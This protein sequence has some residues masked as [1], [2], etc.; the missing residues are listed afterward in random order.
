[1]P[2]TLLRRR[3]SRY[4]V[5]QTETGQ[6]MLVKMPTVMNDSMAISQ[7]QMVQSFIPKLR[8]LS[9]AFKADLEEQR[10]VASETVQN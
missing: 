6:S 5:F 2:E 3:S 10:S 7:Q 4:T 9:M 8:E 1:M